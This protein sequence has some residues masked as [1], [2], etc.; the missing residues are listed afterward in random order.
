MCPELPKNQRG[1][2][3]GAVN[4][5]D[6]V[7]EVRINFA[8]CSTVYLGTFRTTLSN[9]NRSLQ[10]RALLDSGAQR[11]YI[12]L[13]AAAKLGLRP[14]GEETLSHTLFGGVC[15]GEKTVKSYIVRSMSTKGVSINLN[16]LESDK[17]CENLP[18]LKPGPWLTTLKKNKIWISDLEPAT[19]DEI[20]VLIGDD[21][22]GQ[23]MTGQILHLKSRLTALETKLGWVVLG[24]SNDSENRSS[25]HAMSVINL[26]VKDT[27]SSDMLWS[28]EALG[29]TDPAE[30]KSRMEREKATRE[31]FSST[32]TRN[33]EGRYIVRLPW[34]FTSKELH[35]NTKI[36]TA[37]LR[38]TTQKLITNCKLE[39]YGRVFKELEHEGI[40]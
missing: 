36:A 4:G 14:V 18:T 33:E 3:T 11:S 25:T 5:G 6:Q 16:V 35:D 21:Y 1:K 32:V 29:I 23:L 20:D 2:A 34:I 37:R 27:S 26:L 17:I 38:N 31:H 28:L 19:T 39:D 8:E 15:T 7:R 13:T 10:V 12:T 22:Y 40:L 30:H 9:G 24:S